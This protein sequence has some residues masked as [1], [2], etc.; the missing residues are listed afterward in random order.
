[1]NRK[2]P[3]ITPKGLKVWACSSHTLSTSSLG[4][5]WI[6]INN[7]K[8]YLFQLV[9]LLFSAD[10]CLKVDYFDITKRW[11]LESVLN[12]LKLCL[13]QKMATSERVEHELLR[14]LCC[15]TSDLCCFIVPIC[16][17]HCYVIGKVTAH[18]YN[19][20]SMYGPFVELILETFYGPRLSP[21]SVSKKRRHF[22]TLNYHC[23]V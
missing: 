6:N 18:I 1:M 11:F 7:G 21:T 5:Y 8:K 20:K 3:W 23:P 22:I 19:K 2:A 4:L 12:E 9:F 10:Q 17:L 13:I 16:A 15:Q 14:W